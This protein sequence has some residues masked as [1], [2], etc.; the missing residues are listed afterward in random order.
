MG[1]ANG[2]TKDGQ[3]MVN[4]PEAGLHTLPLFTFFPCFLGSVALLCL[5]CAG[6]KTAMLLQAPTSA[7]GHANGNT[8]D[9]QHDDG[10]PASLCPPAF[11]S[12]FAFVSF[13]HLFFW[14]AEDSCSP[15]FR[16]WHRHWSGTAH[17]AARQ[18]KGIAIMPCMKD[19][20]GDDCLPYF[21][22]YAK[23]FGCH[24]STH[25][26]AFDPMD[27]WIQWQM[28]S[29]IPSTCCNILCCCLLQLL[30]PPLSSSSALDL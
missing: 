16:A 22:P 17:P 19:V 1:H 10:D 29:P 11:F 23:H 18:G 26:F 7:V 12:V 15:G 3:L 27:F 8:K 25:Y 20:C 5:L 2:N 9:G 30:C 14:S 6:L 24:T 21:F 4:K 28:L 13:L